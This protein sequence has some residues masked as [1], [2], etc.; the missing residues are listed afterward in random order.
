ME[1]T[2]HILLVGSGAEEFAGEMGVERVDP[3]YFFTEN[4]YR[5][6]LD[7]RKR[8]AGDHGTVGA[9]ALDKAGNLAAATSTGGLTNKR[10]GRVGD[11]PLIGSGTYADNRTCAVSATGTGEEFIRH[12]AAYSI[13]ARMEFGG[14]SVQQAAKDVVGQVLRPGDGGLIAVDRRG[15]LALEFNTDSMRRGAADSSGRFEVRIWE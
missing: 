4:R 5:E 1:R 2:P 8:E 6:L 7:V 9:V 10:A 15:D 14:K 12:A 13:S 11:S 3:A